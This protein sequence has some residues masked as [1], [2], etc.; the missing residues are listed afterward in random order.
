MSETD[1]NIVAVMEVPREHT[2]RY[3]I[4]DIAAR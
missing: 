4:L 1:G 2:N 3:G